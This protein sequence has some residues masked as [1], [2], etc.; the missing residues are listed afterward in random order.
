MGIF[1]FLRKRKEE[2][3][4]FSEVDV[5]IAK[6]FQ[7][8]NVESKIRAFRNAI[9][10]H[11]QEAKALLGQLDKAALMNENIPERIKHIMEGNR[12]NYIRKVTIFLDNITPPEKYE[13]VRGFSEELSKNIDLLSA[14]TQKSYAILKEFVETELKAVVK[15]IKDI[16]IKTAE[17]QM[18]LEKEG[19]NKISVVMAKLK[20]YAGSKDSLQMLRENVLKKEKEL[21]ELKKK[22]QKIKEKIAHIKHEKSFRECQEL[23]THQETVSK[24]I[25]DEK[26]NITNEFLSID[27]ALKKY[28][29]ISLEEKIIASYIKNPVDAIL[30]DEKLSIVLILEKIGSSMKQ[31]ELK[32]RQADKIKA[33]LKLLNR[34]KIEDMRNSLVM[35]IET[36]KE[37][38][39]KLLS[40]NSAMNLSEQESF[41]MVTLDNIKGKQAE[42]DNLS[43]KINRIDPNTIRREVSEILKEFSVNIENG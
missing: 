2:N 10:E 37:I 13:E 26:K 30:S 21:S 35:L 5:W 20:E 33:N 41:L 9:V 17:L 42:I 29:R 7:E 24:S 32:E 31:L 25:S 23:K 39:R 27:R 3:I 43:E 19:L 22:E 8:R 15:K 11:Q 1:D 36:E 14:D 28:G 34:K 38:K 4:R 18:Q 6:Y 12:R 16:E 40:N